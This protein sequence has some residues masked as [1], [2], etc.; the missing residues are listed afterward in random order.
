MHS[1]SPGHRAPRAPQGHQG[2]MAPPEG[3]VSRVIL[4]KTENLVT[5][6]HRASREP[7]ETWA[8]RVRRGILELEPEDPQD[9]EGLQGHQDPLSDLTS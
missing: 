4:G 3:T 5:L 9:P 2:R 1:L 8:S 7:Q 6:G